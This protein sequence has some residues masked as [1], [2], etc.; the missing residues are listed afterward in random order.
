MS[1]L[2]DLAALGG[3][4]DMLLQRNAVRSLSWLAEAIDTSMNIASILLRS[5]P[6]T[7][8]MTHYD[9]MWRAASVL[10]RVPLDWARET[11]SSRPGSMCIVQD[12]VMM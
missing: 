11:R 1:N 8:N 12:L 3:R 2:N 9:T 7:R 10:Y 6:Q 5:W 4:V